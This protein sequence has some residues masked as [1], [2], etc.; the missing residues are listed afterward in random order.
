MKT[1]PDLGIC[2]G[3]Q[4]QSHPDQGTAV[5]ENESR[6][7]VTENYITYF[8]LSLKRSMKIFSV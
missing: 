6:E 2:K 8:L 5:F 1:P 3:F 7:M 4:D